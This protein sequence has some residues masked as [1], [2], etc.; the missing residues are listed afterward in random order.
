MIISSYRSYRILLLLT[1]LVLVST[2][3]LFA[4][5][6]TKASPSLESLLSGGSEDLPEILSSLTDA[7]LPL[8][9]AVAEALKFKALHGDIRLSPDRSEEFRRSV[10]KR[11]K[12]S[13]NRFHGKD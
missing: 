1:F 10:E 7:D 5:P 4:Q 2:L 13:Q 12:G 3:F 11:L 9:L 6:E 8:A